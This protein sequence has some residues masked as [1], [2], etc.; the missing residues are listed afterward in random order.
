MNHR[1]LPVLAAASALAMAL[2]ACGGTL[3]E[4]KVQD[5]IRTGID[6]ELRGKTKEK[7]RAVTCPKDRAIKQ[8]DKFTCRATF[9]DGSSAVVDARQTSD[10]GDVSWEVRGN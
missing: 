8:G 3:D 9:T 1:R 4:T 2:S 7:V 5:A 6:K 10:E